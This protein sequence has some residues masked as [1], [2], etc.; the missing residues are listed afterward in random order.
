MFS[1]HSLL[2]VTVVSL[3]SF[4]PVGGLVRAEEPSQA[5]INKAQ[6]FLDKQKTGKFILGYAH[7]GANYTDHNAKSVRYVKDGDGDGDVI[8]GKFALVYRFD[9]NAS[10][11][12]WTNLAFICDRQGNV[13]EVVDLQQTNAIL[14]Q[15]FLVAN[16]TIQTLGN[17]L[18]EALKDDMSE[19][20]LRIMRRLID[21]ADS[22]GLLGFGLKL[23]QSMG[24]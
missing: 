4:L 18:I 22:K 12:G 14:Q 6:T 1:V 2:M 13:E 11:A 3:A 19:S 7:L 5:A 15:P 16:A 8:P 21:A 17:V 20:D 23:Q 9:W 24:K 10:G